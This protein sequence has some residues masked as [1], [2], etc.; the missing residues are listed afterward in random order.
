MS[1][2]PPKTVCLNRQQSITKALIMIIK[3]SIGH[4]FAY[5]EYKQG[6]G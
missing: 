5:E 4:A 6:D 2:R 1:L 3:K